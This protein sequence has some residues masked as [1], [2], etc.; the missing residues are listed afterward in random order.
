MEEVQK[1]LEEIL[2]K[3][4]AVTTEVKATSEEV[5]GF[6]KQMEDYG[7]DLDGVK[8]RVQEANRQGRP[9]QLEVPLQKGALTNHG[10]PLLGSVPDAAPIFRTAPSSPQNPEEQ[11]GRQ[12]QN[13]HQILSHAD[14]HAPDQGDLRV[15]APRHDFPKFSGEMPLL[16]IDQSTNYFEMFKIPPHQWVQARPKGGAGGAAALGLRKS[17]ALQM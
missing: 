3:L 4:A 9:S 14:R 17:E 13:G 12:E 10:A 5:H 1:T 6:R 16:W 15:R 11:H 7:T 8:H 2:A